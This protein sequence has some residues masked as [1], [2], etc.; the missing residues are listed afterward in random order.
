MILL[1]EDDP[2]SS[3]GLSM[4]LKTAG[5]K[6]MNAADGAEALEM[7]GLH[8]FELVITDL[9]MPKLDGLKLINAIRLKSPNM[10][11]ILMSGYLSKEAGQAI[12]DQTTAF[13]Q[14]PVNPTALIMTVEGMLSKSK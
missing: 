8:S 11:L 5:H 12:I 1:V 13:L 6:V 4:A 14:K 2:T 10:P 7:I 9:V 3:C